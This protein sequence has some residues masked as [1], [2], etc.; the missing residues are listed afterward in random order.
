MLRPIRG[1]ALG[2]S[3]ALALPAASALAACRDDL[4]P[5]K[6]DYAKLHDTRK[7]DLVRKQISKADTALKQHNETVCNRAVT[8]AKKILTQRP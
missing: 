1:L 4:K 5:L 6:D 7:K 3:L 8:D 2:L